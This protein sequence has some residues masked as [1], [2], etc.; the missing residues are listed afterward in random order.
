M[1]APDYVSSDVSEVEITYNFFMKY[2]QKI[3]LRVTL[4]FKSNLPQSRIYFKINA[5]QN[6]DIA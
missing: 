1:Q 3:K 4:L 5:R 6:S 2:T